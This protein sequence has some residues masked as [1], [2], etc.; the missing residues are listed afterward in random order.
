[1]PDEPDDAPFPLNSHRGQEFNYVLSGTLKIVVH[2]HE[3]V[4]NEG[5]SLFFDS[6]FEHGMK[7]LGGKPAQFLAIIF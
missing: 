6:S 7:A 4:L 1:V 2:K 3:L 5:D